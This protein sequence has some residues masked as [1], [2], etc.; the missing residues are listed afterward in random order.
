MHNLPRLAARRSRVQLSVGITCAHVRVAN[1]ENISNDGRRQDRK[2]K[3]QKND[4][5][6]LFFC[7]LCVSVVPV[8]RFAGTGRDPFRRASNKEDLNHRGTEVTE[9]QRSQRTCFDAARA[10]AKNVKQ[11]NEG[12]LRQS[13]HPAYAES[14]EQQS[15]GSYR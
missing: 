5:Q 11:G 7:S 13:I 14:V 10:N 6:H 1:P 9:A 8:Y 3:G 2:I 12:Q 4:G 15:Q